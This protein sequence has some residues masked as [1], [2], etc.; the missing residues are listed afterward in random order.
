[1]ALGGIARKKTEI[2]QSCSRK[3]KE[4]E[5]QG[6]LR[7]GRG[8]CKGFCASWRVSHGQDVRWGDVRGGSNSEEET[9]YPPELACNEG[10]D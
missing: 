6:S 10:A 5:M 2:N 1:M 4:T 3:S 8:D 9:N 7:D